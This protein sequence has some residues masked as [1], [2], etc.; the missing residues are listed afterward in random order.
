NTDPDPRFVYANRTAQR[1]FEYSWDEFVALPSRLSAQTAERAAREQLLAR[2]TAHGFLCGYR[3]LRI[4]KSGP[5][6]WIEDGTVWQLIDRH[7]VRHGQAA[8]F[9][10]WHDADPP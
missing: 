1:C 9:A 7:G 3:G 4:A 6:F 2:V 10:R 5:R 8:L